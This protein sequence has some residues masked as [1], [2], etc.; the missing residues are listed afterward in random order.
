MGLPL[1][2][3]D[4][5]PL[6][7]SL[8][9]LFFGSPIYKLTLARDAP[10]QLNI[11]PQDTWPADADAGIQLAS[12]NFAFAGQSH[13]C[14]LPNFSPYGANDAWRQAVQSFCW[15][16][17][18]RAA[19]GDAA[20]RTARKWVQAWLDAYH[21]YEAQC[22]APGVMGRR[23]A[24]W[25]LLHDFFCASADDD[26]R[27]MVY[28]SIARQSCHLARILPDGLSGLEL[29]EALKGLILASLA[30]PERNVY[31]ASGL[32]QYAQALQSQFLDDG[33]HSSRSPAALFDALR[34]AVEIRAALHAQRR[35]VPQEI[36]DAI[37]RGGIA[38]KF[39]RHGDG[40]FALFNGAQ[41][42]R[43]VMV[44]AVL[45]Q[46][47]IKGRTLKS[48]GASGFE[49]L[50]AGRSLLIM[51]CGTPAVAPNTHAGTLSFELSV[52][53]ERLI[54]NCGAWPGMGAWRAALSSTP[55]HSTLTL[56]DANSC[57]FAGSGAVV[58]RIKRRASF[59]TVTRDD[60][61]GD[62]QLEATHD[63][64]RAQYGIL[65]RRTLQLLQNGEEL[66]GEDALIGDCAGLQAAIR[67]HLH[68]T[69]QASL[70]SDGGAVLLRL[71]SGI[72]WRFRC[73]GAML[74]LESSIYLGQGDQPRRT[75]Q[76]VLTTQTQG[77]QTKVQW[78]LSREKRG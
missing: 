26:F 21:D 32:R 19:G 6:G 33:G 20:R 16:R 69:V 66:N 59:V 62:C 53:R 70:T 2:K 25:V 65:H 45:S 67:F 74:G 55:A 37:A 49:R 64:Y 61:Q 58:R 47:D 68:P 72:G 18:L 50:S 60:Q 31:L 75:L 10:A 15:L 24:N 29:L 36:Q 11:P 30:L 78:R 28:D 8:K 71:P 17:D 13:E 52:G 43:G 56:Q 54:S 35:P 73:N 4:T 48:A 46:A 34:G 39:F 41:E 1:L 51:D 14:P 22:W 57:E 5:P 76:L 38:L 63:G 9:S 12:G 3:T 77:P 27:Y 42:A 40:G 23:L 44:D 7:K